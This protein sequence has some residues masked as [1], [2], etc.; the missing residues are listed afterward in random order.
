MA[1]TALAL[2]SNPI[3]PNPM[4]LTLTPYHNPKP[5][6]SLTPGALHVGLYPNP[7]PN[8]KTYRHIHC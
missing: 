5:H 1:V 4:S 2:N 7:E 6:D 3:N 8:S